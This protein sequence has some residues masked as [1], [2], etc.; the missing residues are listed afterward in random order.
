MGQLEKYGLYVLCLVIFLILGV[1]IWGGEP[2]AAGGGKPLALQNAS[3]AVRKDAARGP[4]ANSA[5][6][7]VSQ[8]SGLNANAFD[9]TELP[10]PSSKDADKTGDKGGKD[11]KGGDGK[12][13]DGKGKASTANAEAGRTHYRIKH[14]DT[15]EE[16][17]IAQLGSR[18][19]V[20]DIKKLNPG[21]DERHLKLDSEIVLPAKAELAGATPARKDAAKDS[22]DAKDA[23]KDAGK[24]EGWR[25]YE[26][27][28]GDT[29][30]GISKSQYHDVHHVD[31][32]K[33]LNPGI[34]PNR[35]HAGLQLKVPLK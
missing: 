1:A 13:A 28:S 31:A 2:Q 9:K 33:K 25:W 10:K 19:Y 18:T 17:A 12:A 7:V 27:K 30:E 8:L 3:E 6:D 23:G 4:V 20:A 34:E 22:K 29:Y 16:I 11:D 32:I 14:G 15:L 24:N 26:V 5:A 35:I 21:L